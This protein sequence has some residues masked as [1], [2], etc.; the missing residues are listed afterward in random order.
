MYVTIGAR[1][2]VLSAGA[3]LSLPTKRRLGHSD[4]LS[5]V[6]RSLFNVVRYSDV[7]HLIDGLVPYLVHFYSLAHLTTLSPSRALQVQK[8]KETLFDQIPL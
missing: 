7:I 1:V 2:Q 4:S 5:L 6:S 3:P 8:R